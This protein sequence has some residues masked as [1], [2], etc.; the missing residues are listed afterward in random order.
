MWKGSGDVKGL[1]NYNKFVVVFNRENTG[2]K[3]IN[4]L[5]WFLNFILMKLLVDIKSFK[6]K[7]CILMKIEILYLR[8]YIFIV[9]Y[10][11]YFF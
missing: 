6:E 4:C 11:F 5:I 7:E 8:F 3:G 9:F 1:N 10:V 2:K